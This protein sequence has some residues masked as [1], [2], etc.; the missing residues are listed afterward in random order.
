VATDPGIAIPISVDADSGTV[1]IEKLAAKLLEL[2]QRVVELGK[3]GNAA[4]KQFG[5]GFGQGLGQKAFDTIKNFLEGIPAKLD[6][7]VH[8]AAAWSNQMQS[9][10]VRTGFATQQLQ[11]YNLAAKTSGTNINVLTRAAQQLTPTLL[12][13]EKAFRDIGLQFNDL[14]G[15]DPG[16]QFDKVARALRG[17]DDPSR[18]LAATVEIFGKRLGPQLVPFINGLEEARK[19]AEELGLVIDQKTL[20]AAADFNDELDTLK[21]TQ[22]GVARSFGNFIA[23]DEDLRDVLRQVTNEIGGFNKLVQE[24]GERFHGLPVPVKIATAGFALFGSTLIGAIPTLT[25]F[26][27]LAGQIKSLGG[28]AG[29]F[30]AIGA[31]LTSVKVAALAAAPALIAVTAA[32]AAVVGG[33]KLGEWL[34]DNVAAFKAFID[35]TSKGAQALGEFLGLLPDEA[36]RKKLEQGV[37][38]LSG[39]TPEQL[40]VLE[41]FKRR[42]AAL[43][44]GT[45]TTAPARVDPEDLKR[46]KELLA[47]EGQL[48]GIAAQRAGQIAQANQQR[49]Q[50]VAQA[51]AEFEIQKQALEDAALAQEKSVDP[52]QIAHLQ[53]V[54]DL[55]IQIANAQADQAIRQARLADRSRELDQSKQL[56]DL[57]RQLNDARTHGLT[58]LEQIENTRQNS[59]ERAQ[60]EH[61]ITIAK[62]QTEIE[63]LG[64]VGEARQ[65]KEQEIAQAER[66]LEKQRQ[67]A[68]AVA[69]RAAKEEQIRDVLVLSQRV[70]SEQAELSRKE[71]ELQEAITRGTLVGVAKI[72]DERERELAALR[73]STA[74]AR[75]KL[76][77]ERASLDLTTGQGRK[78]AAEIDAEIAQKDKLADLERRIIEETKKRE[79]AVAKVREQSEKVNAAL[80]ITLQL[81]GLL[82]ESSGL[83]KFV[84][85]LAAGAQ[86]AFNIGNR[87][88]ELIAQQGKLTTTQKLEAVGAGIGVAGNILKSSQTQNAGKGALSGAA[89]G[90]AFGQAFG[91]QG[92]VIGAIAGGLIGFF[93]GSKFRKIAKDAGKVLGE[94]LSDETVKKIQEDAKKLNLTIKQ[95]SLLN[96]ST[97]IDDTGKAASTFAPQV[98]D[99]IKGIA[100]GSIPAKEGLDELAK[101]FGAVADEAL[102]AGRVGDRALVGIIKQSRA[103]G[104]ESPEIKAFVS[105]QLDSAAAG[106]DKFAALFK[107]QTQEEID[108]LGEKGAEAFKGL[109]DEAVKKLANDTGTIFGAVFNSLVSEKGIVAAVDQMKGSFDVLRKR[110]TDTLGEDAVNKILG[111][112]GAAF[113]TLGNEKLRPIFEGIDG[114]TQAMKGLANAGFLTTDQFT[115]MQKAT[116]TL[117][118]EAI[119]AG[120]D[121]K[122]A[123][124]SI[125]P[126]IQAAISAAEEFG[127]PLDENTQRLKAQAEANGIAF[128]TDPQRAMLDVLV[129]IADVM[130]AKIPESVKK[131]RDATVGGT[132]AMSAASAASAEAINQNIGGSLDEQAMKWGEF[133]VAGRAAMDEVTAGTLDVAASLSED[134]PDAARDALDSLREVQEAA[135]RGINVNVGGGGATGGANGQK[136]VTA[137]VQVNLGINENPLAAADT[138]AQM[139]AFTVNTVAEAIEDR[140]PSIIAAVEGN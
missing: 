82:G 38:A 11:E 128:K 7:A 83:G 9:L 15:A 14:A 71:Q 75:A 3:K 89:Q 115:A 10:A 4:G 102:K 86:Q 56:S 140:V 122:T 119:A 125:A 99:L 74:E 84:S 31:G 134:L 63:L 30:S 95:A 104:V 70:I 44:G 98:K 53:A 51:K 101:S 120:A 123:L 108:K 35:W 18:R 107:K 130:G 62:L 69:A 109:S 49:Q 76:E 19:R 135:A 23:A 32:V 126:S 2:E 88:K 66:V 20:K 16:E 78:R 72:V 57:E 50:S 103:S 13:N 41:D 85:Q 21:E 127:V 6:A 131:M 34:Y 124:L 77:V 37:L 67:I 46:A 117:F 138:A 105:D 8:S 121:Q 1:T 59:I 24:I 80:D 81:A 73:L 12:K 110:L 33:A 92:A 106:F 118:D 43:A 94:G 96:I 93:G 27:A 55:N 132:E 91:P 116:S 52:K 58:A 113:D 111:P 22:E 129:S 29:I 36:E 87:F 45:G 136:N 54:R 25:S 39:A 90:A 60:A 26:L 139:R 64:L 61:D 17:I 47:L 137:N 5:E 114:L 68:D 48:G 133:G 97:A 28:I 100:D 79:I 65:Q 112:F 40:R 42:Q